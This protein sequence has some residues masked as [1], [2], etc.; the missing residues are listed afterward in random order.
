MA[1]ILFIFSAVER[2]PIR[3]GTEAVQSGEGAGIRGLAYAGAIAGLE[4]RHQL[5]RVQR[6]GGTSAG[7]IT[8]LLLVPGYRPDEIAD[9]ISNTNFKNLMMETGWWQ[10]VYTG[11]R[12]ILAGTEVSVSGSGWPGASK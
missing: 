8:A 3:T 1:C 10:A 7:A 5:D 4:S 2:H 11:C 9:P 6:I 12:G